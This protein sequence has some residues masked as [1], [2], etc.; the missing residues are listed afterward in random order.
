MK[1]IFSILLLVF[2]YSSCSE[3]Q[4]V[5]K[6]EDVAA[7][8]ELATKL[9]EKA[10][11]SKA[12]ALFEQIA[13]SYRGKP[14]AEKMFYMYAQSFYKSKQYYISAGR[15]ESFVASYPK[16]EKVQECAFL[17]AVSY[18]KSSP[19]YTLDQ[20]ETIKGIDKMQ[21]FIDE[22]P[23]SEFIAEANV[24]AKILREKLEK[25]AYEIAYQYYKIADYKSAM[26]TLE[27]FIIDFPGTAYAERA[28]YYKF[29]SAFIVAENSFVNKMEQRLIDAKAAHASLMKFNPNTTFKEKANEK[30]AKIEQDLKQFSK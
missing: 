25:K 9:Y 3:Y 23:N 14:Q 26:I 19:V 27:N 13:P 17:E 15:F 1:K 18:S 7:K 4:K 12:I 16:S 22:Y 21:A 29:D 20:T 24:I 6:N 5:L 11:Y 2:L 28:L 30:L 8:F 10:K